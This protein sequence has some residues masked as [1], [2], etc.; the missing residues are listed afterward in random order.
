MLQNG[1]SQRCA[2]V[3]LCAKGG[4]ALFWGAANLPE[5]LSL[6]MGSRS[7][8]IAISRDMGPLRLGL[9]SWRKFPGVFQDSKFSTESISLCGFALKQILHRLETSFCKP[10]PQNSLGEPFTTTLE[11]QPSPDC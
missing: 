1:V 10:T 9:G 7:D 3:E 6:H 8:S 2:C 11:A 4:I 5:T